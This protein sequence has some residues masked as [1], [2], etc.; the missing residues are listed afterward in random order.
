MR[1]T[2][3]SIDSAGAAM[4]VRVKRV[5]VALSLV[6]M[7]AIAAFGLAGTTHA[8]FDGV[9]CRF[10]VAAHRL[11]VTLNHDDANGGI[12][13][14]G[15]A[16]VVGNVFGPIDC[17][18]AQD[19][20]RFN[21][22]RVGVRARAASVDDL[23]FALDLRGGL[24]VP[25]FSDEG[26]GSSEIEFA[27]LFPGRSGSRV[28][29]RGTSGRD[30]IMLGD[31]AWRKGANLNASEDV[32]DPDLR[33][34]GGAPLVYGFGGADV[35]SARG[36]AGF[37]GPYPG[38]L[39]AFGRRGD[40]RLGGGPERD[41]LFGG[42]G[43]DTM[44]GHGGRDFLIAPDRARDV[45]ICGQGSDFAWVDR[46]DRLRRCEDVRTRRSQSGR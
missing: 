1:T 10:D 33:I 38:S 15:D 6:A 27:V 39:V 9:T 21:T 5:V 25:G 3:G 11:T 30:R 16:L 36:G 42:R 20:T 7:A 14:D 46:V 18:G 44:K 12:A 43:H 37:I 4:G 28:P 31:L 22:E 13:R 19:P 41:A 24:F 40:D 32:D 26:D 2:G 35:I 29:I 23:D 45:V 8:G 17:A 34:R